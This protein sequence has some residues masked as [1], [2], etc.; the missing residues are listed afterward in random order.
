MQLVKKK[1]CWSK[2]S[3]ESNTAGLLIRREERYTKEGWPRDGKSRHWSD[4]SIYR[5]RPRAA[6]KHWRLGAARRRSPHGF[7]KDHGSAAT[8]TLDFWPPGLCNDPFWLFEAPQQAVHCYSSAR[9]LTNQAGS[10][11]YSACFPFREQL[12][13][14]RPRVSPHEARGGSAGCWAA[15]GHLLAAPTA[16]MHLQDT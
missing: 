7:W 1:S 14:L 2:V 9:N 12:C 16:N 8:L 5:G 3:P 11:F 10:G 13:S 15:D 4:A 6:G